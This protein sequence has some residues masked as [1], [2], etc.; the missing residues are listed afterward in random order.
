MC[1]FLSLSYFSL[2]CNLWSCILSQSEVGFTLV[3][4][5][6]RLACWRG[7]RIGNT[8]NHKCISWLPPLCS[9][10][11]TTVTSVGHLW[12]WW[13]SHYWEGG[14]LVAIIRTLLSHSVQGKKLWYLCHW[15][16]SVP[17]HHHFALSTL[18]ICCNSGLQLQI[19]K[20]MPTL[21]D[22]TQLSL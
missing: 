17:S 7:L 21:I 13:M 12:K 2:K 18:Q 19:G 10:H 9:Y 1:S 6:R 16:H 15:D 8:N 11:Y 4:W 5:R 22:S 20:F 3:K 14:L